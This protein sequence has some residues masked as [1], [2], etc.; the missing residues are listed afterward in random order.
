[1][2]GAR[3]GGGGSLAECLTPG[4]ILDPRGGGGTHAHDGGGDEDGGG[5]GVGAD[6][7]ARRNASHV[8]REDADEELC[9]CELLFPDPNLFHVPFHVMF[10]FSPFLC[11]SSPLPQV[12]SFLVW[13][14]TR[15]REGMQPMCMGRMLMGNFVM[16]V[17]MGVET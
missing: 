16:R 7:N 13:V 3:L 15:M 14:R 6:G 11:H 1:M 10:P 5:L 2:S 12:V 4:L 9:V 8:Y 17:R